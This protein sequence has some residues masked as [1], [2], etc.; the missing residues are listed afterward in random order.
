[1]ETDVKGK[2]RTKLRKL[3]GSRKHYENN[4]M[5]ASVLVSIFKFF[6]LWYLWK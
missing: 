3:I 2:Y 5:M 4:N 6:M 1:M